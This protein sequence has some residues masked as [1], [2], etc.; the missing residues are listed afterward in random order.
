[1]NTVN[2]FYVGGIYR[3]VLDGAPMYISDD[4]QAGFLPAY[5][6]VPS[7]AMLLAVEVMSS[8]PTYVRV[9][10]EGRLGWMYAIDLLPHDCSM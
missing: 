8:R 4:P 3:P 2:N 1:M 6:E 10:W 5:F 7:S 9:L